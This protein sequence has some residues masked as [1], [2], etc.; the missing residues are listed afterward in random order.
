MTSSG[1]SSWTPATLH[2]H[3]VMHYRAVRDSLYVIHLFAVFTCFCPVLFI[4][5]VHVYIP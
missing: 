5:I 1:S 4:I 3:A 2:S